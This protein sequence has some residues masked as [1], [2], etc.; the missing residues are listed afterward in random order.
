MITTFLKFSESVECTF[1]FMDRLTKQSKP[2]KNCIPDRKLSFQVLSGGLQNWRSNR[3]RSGHCGPWVAWQ[4]PSWRLTLIPYK[5]TLFTNH[6][7]PFLQAW[8]Q[9]PFHREFSAAPYRHLGLSHQRKCPLNICKKMFTANTH[10]ICQPRSRTWYPVSHTWLYAV[11][12]CF[13][14]QIFIFNKYF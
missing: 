13:S 7:S 2:L 12:I 9:N 6:S 8:S 11:L 5:G 14:I 10:R 3:G 1:L 4:E